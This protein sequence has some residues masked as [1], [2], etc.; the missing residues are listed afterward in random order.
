LSFAI[1]NPEIDVTDD[2]YRKLAFFT[3]GRKVQKPKDD[4]YQEIAAHWN[5]TQLVSDEKT[6][7]GS[8]MSR[9][10]E[11]SSDGEQ[12]FETIHVDRGK[13]KGTL[14]VRYVY[15]ASAGIG[16]Q[17]SH[18]TDPNQPVLKRHVD[19][20]NSVSTPDGGQT[21]QASDPDQPVLKRKPDD[22]SATPSTQTAPASLPT[23]Q[24]NDPDKPVLRRHTDSSNT[25]SQ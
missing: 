3:D 16:S 6:P 19:T 13:S 7:Q 17:A 4:S 25:S 21:G 20:T 8:T 24:D 2:H 9:T 10:F 23:T 11:L 12:F 18:E 15:D 22:S 1:T 5:G 14:V